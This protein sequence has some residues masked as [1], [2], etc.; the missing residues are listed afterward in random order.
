MCPVSEGVDPALFSCLTVAVAGT[1]RRATPA[2]G[3]GLLGAE[4]G[5][6]GDHGSTYTSRHGEGQRQADSG[7]RA[8]LPEQ[9]AG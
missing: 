9:D 3:S 4:G 5:A 2:G 7:A 6:G 1:H 8:L